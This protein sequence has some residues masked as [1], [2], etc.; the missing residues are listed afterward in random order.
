MSWSSLNKIYMVWV[1]LYFTNLS[2]KVSFINVKMFSVKI[3]YYSHKK[4]KDTDNWK[5]LSFYNKIEF[6]NINIFTTW[7]CKPLIFHAYTI[8]SN[9]IHNLKYQRSMTLGWADVGFRKLEFVAK[10]QFLWHWISGLTLY[11]LNSEW[12][13]SR[14]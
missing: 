7:Y 10:T 13:Y 14:T 2:D 1:F 8:W 11:F 12:M 5:E 9:R 6:S 3:K 4:M